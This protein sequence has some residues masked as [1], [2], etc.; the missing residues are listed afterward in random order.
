[1]IHYTDHTPGRILQLDGKEYLYFGGTSYLGIQ[2][3]PE[4][5]E[6][7]CHHQKNAA[8]SH[9]ASRL[10]N[11]RLRIY[12]EAEEYL[13]AQGGCESALLLSSGFLA[14]QLL[15]SF[16]D[17]PAYTLF[18]APGA[19]AALRR[20]QHLPYENVEGLGRAIEDHLATGNGSTPVVLTDSIDFSG[21]SFPDYPELATLPLHALILVADDSH[22]VGVLGQRGE[23][24]VSRLSQLGAG[25][26]LVCASMGK[27]LGIQAGM[28]L[29]TQSRIAKLR[30]TAFFAG[31]SPPPPAHI[32]AYLEAENLYKARR[33]A[34]LAVRDQF[35]Q[36]TGGLPPC[37]RSVPH[38]PLYAFNRPA[39][40]SFLDRN[41]ILVTDFNYP[42]TSGETLP[43]RL[44]LSAHH[45]QEDI[46]KLCAV[47]R[48]HFRN[49]L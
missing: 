21:K 40:T 30:E 6:L 32:H 20:G 10:S 35:A 23:G 7:L 28:V 18:Y 34:L 44:V 13:A 27:A 38:H 8:G 16:F 26:L 39:L 46:Q 17:S 36:G 5:R 48:D 31:A 47:L 24:A 14:G 12:E 4:F 11:L 33:K 1:M 15:A 49:S 3:D 2:A 45:R 42:S 22:G 9:G 41:Q 43:G 25:E 37:F 29:G 19:H